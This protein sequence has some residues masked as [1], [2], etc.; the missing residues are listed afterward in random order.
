MKRLRSASDI[1]DSDKI[2][3]IKLV[4]ALLAKGVS[5]Q[6]AVKYINHLTVLARMISRPFDQ[7][8][9][10]DVEKLVIW[11][12]T[13]NY[14]EHTKHD[15]KVILKKF[16]QGSVVAEDTEIVLGTIY[17]EGYV[18][19]DENIYYSGEAITSVSATPNWS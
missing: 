4:E 7:L 13:A 8:G 3:V 10:E 12:N 5:K 15:Y 16:Y 17:G 19:V 1:K 2:S 11:I 14:T 6:Q 9:R 18:S